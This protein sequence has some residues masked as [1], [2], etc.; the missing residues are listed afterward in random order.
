MV[1]LPESEQRRRQPFSFPGY[2]FVQA[3]SP[4]ADVLHV[5]RRQSQ[6]PSSL[7]LLPAP[8]PRTPP[9]RLSCPLRCSPLSCGSRGTKYLPG[10][11]TYTAWCS[12]PADTRTSR[13]VAVR[14]PTGHSSSSCYSSLTFLDSCEIVILSV[15]RS[16]PRTSCCGCLLYT[17]P[18]PRD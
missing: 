4:L 6:H 7:R 5:L 11:I 15:S 3:L 16:N 13:T 9:P 17:S 2:T 1:L 12:F 8:F 14:L 18:S 10:L